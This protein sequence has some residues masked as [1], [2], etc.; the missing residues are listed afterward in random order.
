[1]AT[2]KKPAKQ[3]SAIDED[4][5]EK[6]KNMPWRPSAKKKKPLPAKKKSK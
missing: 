6:D 5:Q 4:E 2:K 1:M 3:S